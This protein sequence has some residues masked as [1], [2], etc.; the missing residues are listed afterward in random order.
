MGI[1]DWANVQRLKAGL[2]TS[3]EQKIRDA[4]VNM[5]AHVRQ[6]QQLRKAVDSFRGRLAEPEW[7]DLDDKVET[8][9]IQLARVN[10][11][12][13]EA[14]ARARADGALEGLGVDWEGVILT[15][16]AT[17]ATIAL[18]FLFLSTG[19]AA[20]AVGAMLAALALAATAVGFM[21]SKFGGS[22]GDTIK[23]GSSALVW[24]GLIG[25][26]AFALSKK[27]GGW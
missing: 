14:V 10:T 17:V 9:R 25:L 3:D 26:A 24:L 11:M 4:W 21:I 22:A 18:G 27:K 1:V 5:P 8:A 19:A 7:L 6:W 16:S 15:V 12:G 23:A 13:L 20:L 2:L